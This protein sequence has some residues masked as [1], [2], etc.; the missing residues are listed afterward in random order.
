MDLGCTLIFSVFSKTLLNVVGSTAGMVVFEVDEFP[1]ANAKKELILAVLLAVARKV[2]A[3]VLRS[4][5]R[6]FQSQRGER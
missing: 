6:Q 4:S 5:R 3:A 2:T 1:D